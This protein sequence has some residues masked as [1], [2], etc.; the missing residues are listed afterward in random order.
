MTGWEDDVNKIVGLGNKSI[1]KSYYPELKGKI[2]ELDHQTV[3]YQSVL[4]SIPDSIAITD[5]DGVITQVN[6]AFVALFGYSGSEVEGILLADLYAETPI[7]ILDDPVW[8]RTAQCYRAKDGSLLLGETH[9]TDIADSEARLLGHLAVI[10]DLSENIAAFKRHKKMEERLRQAQKLEAFGSLAGGIAHDFNNILSGIIGFGEL[11]QLYDISDH[12]RVS[13]CVQQMLQ[14]SYRA[15]DLVK[16]ILLFSRFDEGGLIALHLVPVIEEALQIIRASLPSTIEIKTKLDVST[17]TIMGDA[18]QI[19]QI[20]MNLCTNSAHAMR[21]KGGVLQVSLSVIDSL[22]PVL[23][24]AGMTSPVICLEV[25]DDGVGI[26]PEIMREIFEPYFTTKQRHE[27]TGFGL[28]LVQG[29]V[30]NHNGV[31]EVE[32]QL[33]E[34]AVFKVYFPLETES[35]PVGGVEQGR[36]KKMPK[37]GSRILLVDDEEQQ[38][39]W[40]K[41]FL[42]RLGFVV[43][44]FVSS[45][46][47]LVFFEKNADKIDVVITDQTMPHL[48]G[49]RLAQKIRE[50][51]RDIPII[52]CTGFANVLSQEDL[53]SG[54]ISRVMNKPVR[55][56]ELTDTLDEVLHEKL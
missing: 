2:A 6:P 25:A 24:D 15:R 38:I 44:S 4:N 11:V 39:A 31:V 28:A 56:K 22:L 7:E 47:S 48:T 21:E 52:L 8:G 32:S 20:V 45:E 54:N 19:H 51:R 10:R 34:G 16:Q 13:H 5:S 43:D 42:T 40:C 35:I 27:G 49:I 3:F 30:R 9:F 55:L 46:E 41:E 18:T 14:A 53:T 1:H 26:A 50:I 29:I 36:E 23:R 37:R 33:G 17:D 12:E